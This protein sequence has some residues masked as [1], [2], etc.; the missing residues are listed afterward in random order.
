MDFKNPRAVQ[1]FAE[2]LNESYRPVRAEQ[3]R[4]QM[5]NMCMYE[6]LQWIYRGQGIGTQYSS[7][8]LNRSPVSWNPDFAKLRVTC[9]RMARFIQ[10]S[11]AATCPEDIRVDVTP[12]DADAGVPA[13]LAA[14]TQDDLLNAVIL[15]SGL[16]RSWKNA[17]FLRSITGCW[18][19]GMHLRGGDL[20]L[21]MGPKGENVTIYDQTFRCYDFDGINLT[22]DPHN[23][24]L[25]LT[26][27]DCVVY[28]SVWTLHK[29]QRVL[30]ITLD[31]ADCK[32]VG[33]LTPVFQDTNQLSGGRLYAAYAAHSRTKGAKVHQM[34]VKSGVNPRFDRMY[35]A[36]E[37]AS[38]DWNVLN[39]DDP[40]NPF[41]GCGLPFMLLTG[42][43]RGDGKGWISD[44]SMMKDD[45]DA[46]NLAK[47]M[48][49]RQMQKNSGWQ[50]L[51]DKK[52]LSSGKSEEEF[53]RQFTNTV[54]GSIFYEGGDRNR[55]VN[56][57][58]LVNYPPPQQF[59]SMMADESEESM[60]KQIHRSE[61]HFGQ[62]KTHVA[63]STEQMVLEASDDVLGQRSQ[64]DIMRGDAFLRTML[65]TAIGL[66]KRGSPGT[67]A[68]AREAG[69]QPEDFALIS[70][71]DENN[72]PCSVHI[73]ESTVR[74]KS[75]T[76]KRRDL[77][78]TL[79]L[80]AID[81]FSYR[82]AYAQDLDSPITE[83]D[84]FYASKARKAAFD[85]LMG[86]DWEAIPLGEYSRLFIAEFRKA[87]LDRRAMSDPVT[88]Q[89]LTK[90]IIDQT[91]ADAAEVALRQA[92]A[93]GG[94]PQAGAA[95]VSE[96]P[97][98]DQNL[99]EIMSA[100]ES[101]GSP[102]A[103]MPT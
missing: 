20:N 89:R 47:T 48:L 45:Q 102:N 35:I 91:E 67:L 93:Q 2:E 100:L 43:P 26:E 24:H 17:N 98:Q 63:A 10:K 69:L 83:D 33:E 71:F 72:P 18:G 54:A 11:A 13:S 82:M 56:P 79:S 53:E 81:A 70:G 16:L 78:N 75:H 41:G 58:Q 1:D 14:Q 9:N 15:S 97:E 19:I 77:D 85:V 36:I 34:H 90:A 96:V 88:K 65:G 7:N 28:S 8:Y 46:L 51:I 86:N 76:A 101:Q 59:L 92:L 103:P 84:R 29:I 73:R 61:G 40:T 94:Q 21:P 57:P 37:P 23:L 27:H 25:E 44:A 32:T 3:A 52:S 50:W 6:G 22:L 62:A 12:P 60:R 99:S 74:Y 68:I 95:P 39:I 55:P 38:G 31:E 87:L 5:V 49:F 66:C 64:D 4:T 80:Q 30:G 42:H